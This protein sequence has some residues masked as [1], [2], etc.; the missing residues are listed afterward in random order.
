M[1]MLKCLKWLISETSMFWKAW[2]ITQ[3]N[4]HAALKPWGCVLPPADD[5]FNFLEP[6]RGFSI[7]FAARVDGHIVA[8]A[9]A[10]QAAGMQISPKTAC[11][12]ILL[13]LK[14]SRRGVASVSVSA[15]DFPRSQNQSEKTEFKDES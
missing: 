9:R 2:L 12:R 7:F 10:V 5:V 15:R 3:G 14:T 1:V 8:T 11:P 13:L 6:L 4:S